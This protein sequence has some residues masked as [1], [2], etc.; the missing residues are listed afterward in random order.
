MNTK[1][2]YC[3]SLKF[4]NINEY[5]NKYEIFNNKNIDFIEFR[6][7]SL[8]NN[9][10]YIEDIISH[11]NNIKTNKTNILTIRTKLDG[12]DIDINLNEYSKYILYCLINSNCD[13]I[14]I[15]YNLYNKNK[16]LF[17][18]CIK[19]YNK[20][21]ILSIHFFKNCFT[22]DY[23]IDLINE[24]AKN[25]SDIIKI[26]I[27]P[28]SREDVFNIMEAGNLLK[29]KIK[30]KKFILIA[31]SKLGILSRVFTEYSNSYFTFIDEFVNDVNELGQCNIKYIK[32]LRK[33]L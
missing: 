10:Y 8:L 22:K 20:K 33:L 1:Q 13:Y 11:L 32:E 18:D 9:N 5:S 26:A 17:D 2:K 27:M 25:K 12:G 3:Q 30:N 21:V 28:K 16:K 6:I 15:E 24:M 23:Y 7:D 31:M 29:N 4:N 14:D 19:K